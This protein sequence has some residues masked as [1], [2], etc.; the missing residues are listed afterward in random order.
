MNLYFLD[1]LEPGCYSSQSVR[2]DTESDL[3]TADEAQ[4]SISS[5]TDEEEEAVRSLQYKEQSNVKMD[6]LDTEPHDLLSADPGLW[7]TKLS[8]KDRTTIVSKLAQREMSNDSQGKPFPD[9]LKYSK[10]ANGRE[11]MKRDWLIY[12]ESADALFCI[13]CVLFSHGQKRPSYSPLNS[14]QGYKMC[15]VKWHRMY[16]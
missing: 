2:E 13:P 3:K 6:T 7:P 11:K 1:I 16:D 9:Y 8:D 12:S 5:S 15:D 10:A 14:E 4:D